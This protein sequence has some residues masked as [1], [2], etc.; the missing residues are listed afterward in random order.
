MPDHADDAP[1]IL[2]ADAA[3]LLGISADHL[4][5]LICRGWYTARTV[6]VGGASLR[7]VDAPSLSFVFDQASKAGDATTSQSATL[8]TKAG[9]VLGSASLLAGGVASFQGGAST[10]TGSHAL[11]GLAGRPCVAVT[12]PMLVHLVTFVAAAIYATVVYYAWQAY[13]LR[14][15]KVIDPAALPTYA[16]HL[17]PAARVILLREIVRNNEK[18]YATV[19]KKAA[20]ADRA[21][22]A[23]LVEVVF[24][25]CT[26]LLVAVLPS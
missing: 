18:N 3:A 14:A 23:F 9:F 11:C 6:S 4:D 25:A 21:L 24:L 26:L 12:A 7:L 22:R 10:F 19:E 15:F 2:A 8:D 16:L 1:A 5:D 20:Y 17:E 13:R